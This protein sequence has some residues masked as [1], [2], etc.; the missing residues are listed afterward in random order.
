MISLSFFCSSENSPQS[1]PSLSSGLRTPTP[2]S[3][4][5]SVAADIVLN[6]RT[7]ESPPI[8]SAR[9]LPF[10]EASTADTH[11]N[12]DPSSTFAKT[13][14]TRRLTPELSK[15]NITFPGSLTLAQR[16]VFCCIEGLRIPACLRSH[17][18]KPPGF[19]SVCTC[20]ESGVIKSFL[21][22]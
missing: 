9:R 2:E 22:L 4:S 12:G 10:A 14:S 5:A 19:L 20:F 7:G 21:R 11:Q 15:C 16:T 1:S 3:L 18:S 17:Y 13:N 6:S 8:A